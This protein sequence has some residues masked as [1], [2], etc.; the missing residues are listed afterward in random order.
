MLSLSSETDSCAVSETMCESTTPLGRL[1]N[2]IVFA[3]F[4]IT[5]SQPNTERVAHMIEAKV[6]SVVMTVTLFGFLLVFSLPNSTMTGSFDAVAPFKRE[7]CVN[8]FNARSVFGVMRSTVLS[9]VFKDPNSFK[10]SGVSVGVVIFSVTFANEDN[11]IC[12]TT[13]HVGLISTD[14]SYDTCDLFLLNPHVLHCCCFLLCFRICLAR[15]LSA[16]MPW[17]PKTPDWSCA[18]LPLPNPLPPPG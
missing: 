10:V 16:P 2:V 5:T 8:R 1:S 6:V 18:S 4:V 13:F 12:S 15:S 14:A 7:T 3:F 17:S 9:Y 11:W